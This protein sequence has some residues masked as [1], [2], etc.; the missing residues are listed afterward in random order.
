MFFEPITQTDYIPLA[1]ENLNAE[2]ISV[3][4]ESIFIKYKANYPDF[5]LDLSVIQYN[6]VSD[7]GASLL[8]A[9]S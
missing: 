9:L 4:L 3:R 6:N 2:L 1:N 7:F 5:R 8:V